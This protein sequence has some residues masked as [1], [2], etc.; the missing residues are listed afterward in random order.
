MSTTEAMFTQEEIKI[1]TKTLKKLRDK[2]DPD[3]NSHA[4]HAYSVVTNLI[5]YFEFFTEKE[6]RQLSPTEAYDRAMAIISK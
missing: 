6:N 2:C 5:T 3:P 4:Y 1:T